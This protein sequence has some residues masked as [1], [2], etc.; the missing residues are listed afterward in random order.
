MTFLSDSFLTKVTDIGDTASLIAITTASSIYLFCR[1]SGRAAVF[2][3]MALLISAVLIGVLKV[4]FIGCQKGLSHHGILSPS[5][6][7]AD[8]AAVFWAYAILMRSQLD[9][10]RRFLPLLALTLLITCIAYSRVQLGFHTPAEVAVG[11]LVGFTA[12][13]LAYFFVLRG[14][15]AG[16][17]DAYALMLWVVVAAFLL[18]GQRLPVEN[19]IHALA[20]HFK[21]HVPFCGIID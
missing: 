13:V 18:N 6:H 14:R 5:G 21:N 9:A 10:K 15:P 12:V 8:S 20:Q 4:Y 19:W 3:W 7:T 11:M 2:L 1:K 17:F 16:S